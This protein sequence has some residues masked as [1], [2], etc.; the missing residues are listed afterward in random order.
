MIHYR[1][2]LLGLALVLFVAP[3]FAQVGAEDPPVYVT[4]RLGQAVWI[5]YYSVMLGASGR[6]LQ[7]AERVPAGARKYLIRKGTQ[8]AIGDAGEPG[9]GER[10]IFLTVY[11]R[12]GPDQ[13]VLAN[14]VVSV[15][16]STTKG[17]KLY[18]DVMP[19]RTLRVRTGR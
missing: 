14:K 8:Y 10:R 3:S 13:K 9:V 18:V 19:D 1:L 2:A 12:P 15:A 6:V 17:R 11:D 5:Q 4:N 16:P 7:E